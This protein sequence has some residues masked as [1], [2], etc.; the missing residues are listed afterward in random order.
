META[1]STKHNEASSK[2][3]N[4]SFT[5]AI[6]KMINLYQQQTNEMFS[7]YNNFL[8][9]LEENKNFWNPAKTFTDFFF[10]NN[11]GNK[12]FSSMNGFGSNASANFFNPFD[13]MLKQI[14]NYNT[15]LLDSMLQSNKDAGHLS[16]KFQKNLQLNLEASKEIMN[17]ITETYNKRI[18]FN[19]ES[20]KDLQ[21]EINE[22]INLVMER[23]QKLWTDIPKNTEQTRSTE[24]KFSKNND[25]VMEKKA[26]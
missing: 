6:P 11:R 3:A 24:D 22:Q 12:M 7:F 21:K 15:D 2:K 17:A 5:E 13:Q 20:A 25:R 9:S 1:N 10:N 18:E 16:E 19:L 14:N 26:H 23:N 4:Q 8:N